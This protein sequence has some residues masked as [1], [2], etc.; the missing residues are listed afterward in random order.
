MKKLELS[1]SVVLYKNDSAEIETL[2]NCVSKTRLNYKLYLVDNSPDDRLQTLA[3][4][5]NIEYIFNN[6]NVGFGHAQNI[7]IERSLDQSIYHLIL[8]P[9]ISFEEGT[10]ENIFFFMQENKDIGQLMPKVFYPDGNVQKL[11]KLLP[12]PFDLIGRR[13]FGNSKLFKKRND[14]YELSYFAYNKLLDTPNL[15]GC[16]MFLRTDVLKQV[17]GFDTRYF[18]YLEDFDLTR[19][20]N[21]VAR[22]VFYPGASVTHGFS[23][24]SYT[25]PTLFRYHVISAIKYFNKWGW[26]FDKERNVLNKKVLSQL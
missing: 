24:G 12:H 25:N 10:L 14:Q 3:G 7:A 19:R 16:F 13:F 1:I 22:T 17:G 20:I 21:K 15:S 23:K 8:N 11:C 9:D 5:P 18:M 26:F 4:T 6:K 2:I